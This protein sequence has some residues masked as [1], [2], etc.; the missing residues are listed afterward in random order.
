MQRAALVAL[1]VVLFG[2]QREPR[3]QVST[4][5]DGIVTRVDT[6]TGKSDVLVKRGGRLEWKPVSE[7]PAEDAKPATKADCSTFAPND[8]YRD[9]FGC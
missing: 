9:I 4:G 2:C 6:A 8:P 3:Y 7:A 1:A 5:N